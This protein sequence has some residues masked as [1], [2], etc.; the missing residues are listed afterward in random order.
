MSIHSFLWR[1]YQYRF[2]WHRFYRAFRYA[3]AR[4]SQDDAQTI[5][6]DCQ[7]S[8]GWYPLMILTEK[9]VFEM[10]ADIHGDAA[11]ALAPYIPGA[12]DYV[13]SKWESP[14]DGYWYALRLALDVV[15]DGAALDGVFPASD[16]SISS[17]TPCPVKGI[18][19]G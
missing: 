6:R 3:M 17:S 1:Y 7:S 4:L 5:I 9:D 19:H 11:D 15:Q 13:G 14:G 16:S 2:R 12:C 10:A 8:A 18:S